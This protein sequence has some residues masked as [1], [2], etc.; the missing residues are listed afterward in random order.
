MKIVFLADNRSCREELSTEHGLSVYV[1]TDRHRVLLD[2]GA[3]D[4]FIRNAEKQGVDLSKVDYVFISHGHSDHIGGL[5]YFGQTIPFAI[6]RPLAASSA[7]L[8]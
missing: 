4:L 5:P 1:E 2:T 3:S 6:K 7:D 8:Q